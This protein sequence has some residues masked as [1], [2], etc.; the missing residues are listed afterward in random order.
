MLV[1]IVLLVVNCVVCKCV[2]VLTVCMGRFG[3]YN[4]CGWV[5]HGCVG[6]IG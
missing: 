3:G 2:L 6:F 4:E 1:C 5:C